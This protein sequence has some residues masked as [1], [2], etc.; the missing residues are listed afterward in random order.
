MQ[1]QRFIAEFS[2]PGFLELEAI[3]AADLAAAEIRADEL[4][5]TPFLGWPPRRLITVS[6]RP[7]NQA[8]AVRPGD[9]D[10]FP[11]AVRAMRE[12]RPAGNPSLYAAE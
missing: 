11:N 7:A 10:S 1:L 12:T 3:F 8:K 2:A 6:V 4:A 5:D 9:T